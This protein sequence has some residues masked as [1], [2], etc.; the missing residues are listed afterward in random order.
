MIE[1]GSVVIDIST[2]EQPQQIGRF[3]NLG[4]VTARADRNEETLSATERDACDALAGKLGYLPLA[5][6]QAAAYIEQQG[7]GFG[8]VDYLR[9]YEQATAKLL[10]GL[11][12]HTKAN[13]AE[14]EPLMRRALSLGAVPWP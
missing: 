8:F 12:L 3:R 6:E 7:S 5:L 10:L 11:C 9:L 2:H 14:A 1:S 13:Y 4:A